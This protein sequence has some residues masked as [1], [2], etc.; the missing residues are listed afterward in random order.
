[1]DRRSIR[2][3]YLKTE[4]LQYIHILTLKLLLKERQQVGRKRNYRDMEISHAQSVRIVEKKGPIIKIFSEF[5][6]FPTLVAPE[7]S[8][9]HKHSQRTSTGLDFR[10]KAFSDK[11]PHIHGI[12]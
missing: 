12:L 11:V 4:Q 2:D 10:K 8:S 6:A 5:I 1:M 3:V 9:R 7:V